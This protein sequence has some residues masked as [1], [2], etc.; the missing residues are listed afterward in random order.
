MLTFAQHP[1]EARHVE[2]R[3]GDLLDGD[4]GGRKVV[5]KLLAPSAWC[6]VTLLEKRPQRLQMRRDD[7]FA[8]AAG[9]Q[10]EQCRDNE[11]APLAAARTSGASL[12]GSSGD[13]VASLARRDHRRHRDAGNRSADHRE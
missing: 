8:V 12:S 11:N 9:H 6:E 3:V 10:R 2:G 5:D 4:I 7:W 13:V 1:L